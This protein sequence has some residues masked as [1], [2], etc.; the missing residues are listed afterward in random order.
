[1]GISTS[2]SAMGSPTLSP[3]NGMRQSATSETRL[4][5]RTS[6]VATS[7]SAGEAD[8]VPLTILSVTLS[9]LGS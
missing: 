5:A 1:M 7:G 3:S 8:G 6:P 4:P 9:V 2:K